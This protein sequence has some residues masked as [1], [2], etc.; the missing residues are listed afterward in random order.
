MLSL[1]QALPFQDDSSTRRQ[2]GVSFTGFAASPSGIA[3]PSPCRIG[4]LSSSDAGG[5][6]E[7][8]CRDCACAL[9]SWSVPFAGRRTRDQALC[10]SGMS[11]PHSVG[12]PHQSDDP[13]HAERPP[14]VR[15]ERRRSPALDRDHVAAR[16]AGARGQRGAVVGAPGRGRHDGT[17]ALSSSAPTYSNERGSWPFSRQKRA[18]STFS[19]LQYPSDLRR[20]L[21]RSLSPGKCLATEIFLASLDKDSR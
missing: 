10:P 12:C 4:V 9:S 3:M 7:S 8:S 16:G 11:A 2:A 14:A 21:I 5:Q 13:H 6:S 15:P 17:H 1:C 18:A 20:C 19:F